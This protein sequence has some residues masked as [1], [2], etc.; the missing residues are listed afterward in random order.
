[1]TITN[2]KG[3]LSQDEIERMVEQA[4]RY[5]ADD[6]AAAACVAA[7]NRFEVLAATLRKDVAEPRVAVALGAARV[8]AARAILDAAVDE[9]AVCDDAVQ[10]YAAKTR[11]LER[12]LADVA[13]AASAGVA[14]AAAA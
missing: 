5:K 7:R 12:E 4:E 10:F 3:R 14:N 8:R 1:M 6:A 2:D 11:E 13:D 9:A